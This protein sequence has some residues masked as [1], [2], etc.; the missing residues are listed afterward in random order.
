MTTDIETL[1]DLRNKVFR[2]AANIQ[3][4]TAVEQINLEN[5]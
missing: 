2:R 4:L 5:E 1:A 3:R